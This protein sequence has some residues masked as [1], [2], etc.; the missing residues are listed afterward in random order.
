MVG[1]VKPH[2]HTLVLNHPDGDLAPVMTAAAALPALETLILDY[3]N[4]FDSSTLDGVVLIALNTIRNLS[5]RGYW[6]YGPE[7]YDEEVEEGAEVAAVGSVAAVLRTLPVLESLE[8]K[9][10]HLNAHAFVGVGRDIGRIPG[11]LGM[12]ALLSAGALPTLR[13]LT[14]DGWWD[15]TDGSIYVLIDNAAKVPNLEEIRLKNGF[16]GSNG[17]EALAAAGREGRWPNL[18]VFQIRAFQNVIFGRSKAACRALLQEAWPNL[19]IIVGA[20]PALEV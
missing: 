10:C 1:T 17:F 4:F 16:I 2:L 7:E 14:T 18:R 5:L 8:I 13:R 3:A 19:T 15:D 11:P 12:Q 9:V 20:T 6:W